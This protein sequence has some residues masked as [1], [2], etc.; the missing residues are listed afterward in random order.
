MVKKKGIISEEEWERGELDSKKQRKKNQTGYLTAYEFE[1]KIDGFLSDYE[2]QFKLTYHLDHLENTSM[3]QELVNEIVLW[4]VNRYVELPGEILHEI[5]SL[6]S[7]SRGEHRKSVK[8]LDKLLDTR[9][10][11]IAMASTILRFRNPDVFQIIDRH[12]YRAVYGEKL[13][14]KAY[15]SNNYKMS[16]YFGYLDKLIELSEQRNIDF[17]VLDRLL[18]VFD[19]QLNGKL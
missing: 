9:G 3:S 8:V 1:D 13:P 2:Y 19:K 15:S 6:S 11:D 7:L 12:A 4:K 5:D 18:Y 10:V 16:V 17:K 14:V